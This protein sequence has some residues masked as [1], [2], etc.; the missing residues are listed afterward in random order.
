M[1]GL[2]FFEPQRK[3]LTTKPQRHKEKQGTKRKRSHVVNILHG[4]LGIF[5]EKSKPR[6]MRNNLT[7][8]TLRHEEKV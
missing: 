2:S 5:G 4:I 7:T 8:K 6:I 1:T 3:K